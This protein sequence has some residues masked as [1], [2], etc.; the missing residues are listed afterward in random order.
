MTFWKGI[1]TPI[2]VSVWFQR[3][4]NNNLEARTEELQNLIW[5]KSE[6]LQNINKRI[7][8]CFTSFLVKR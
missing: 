6:L 7:N 2:N 8:I 1:F 5:R 4:K 3:K